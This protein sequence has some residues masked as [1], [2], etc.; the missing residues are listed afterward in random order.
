MHASSETLVAFSEIER[1]VEPLGGTA[2]MFPDRGGSEATY[3]NDSMNFELGQLYELL[4][5]IPHTEA[6]AA[7]GGAVGVGKAVEK[8]F[9]KWAQ[10]RE[11][12]KQTVKIEGYGEFTGSPKDAK[13][14]CE[15]AAA[16]MAR[17]RRDPK[18][19]G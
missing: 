7:L 11:A 12:S 2:H 6:W 14:F 15:R 4:V 17:R 8:A 18:P 9:E 3:R 1:L 13:E 5:Q 16:E 19:K 10:L